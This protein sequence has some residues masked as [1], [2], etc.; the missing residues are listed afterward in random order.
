[1]ANL[2]LKA[3]AAKL[4]LIKAIL[5]PL[6]AIALPIGNLLSLPFQKIKQA[7]LVKAA[8]KK[9]LVDAKL[10]GLRA[11]KRKLLPIRLNSGTL[12]INLDI[13][14]ISLGDNGEVFNLNPNSFKSSAGNLGL[15]IDE[16]GVIKFGGADSD[17]SLGEAEVSVGDGEIL[18]LNKG[19]FKQHVKGPK[20]QIGGEQIFTLKHPDVKTSQAPT[21]ISIGGKRFHLL[22]TRAVTDDNEIP[23]LGTSLRSGQKLL[24]F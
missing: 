7:F 12:G 21:G 19:A 22:D 10:E 2:L 24:L 16:N 5:A 18:L 3:K 9:A 15:T 14:T 1:M 13:P 20:I 11:T 17:V 8:F 23:E 6:K 4:R